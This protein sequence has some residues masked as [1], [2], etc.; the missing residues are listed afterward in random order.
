MLDRARESF[1]DEDDHEVFAEEVEL[2]SSKSL[3]QEEPISALS[4]T[5]QLQY[6]RALAK[7]VYQR[8][9]VSNDELIR[10]VAEAWKAHGDDRPDHELLMAAQTEV[11]Q[12]MI[13]QGSREADVIPFPQE[14]ARTAPNEGA[15]IAVGE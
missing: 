7:E 12:L 11:A 1:D 2:H 6:R 9:A 4:F 14:R 8:G 3:R 15:D 13:R 5:E 10:S